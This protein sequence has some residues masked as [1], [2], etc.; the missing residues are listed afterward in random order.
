M[1]LEVVI[2]LLR[3]TKEIRDLDLGFTGNLPFLPRVGL[4]ADI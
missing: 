3:S 1:S 4:Q 2:R